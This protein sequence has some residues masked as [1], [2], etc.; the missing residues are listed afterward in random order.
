MNQGR[1]ALG[2]TGIPG[3]PAEAKE[4]LYLLD[5][6]HSIEVND[7]NKLRGY[8]RI[9]SCRSA[10]SFVR[11]RT[12]PKTFHAFAHQQG[13]WEIEVL[14]PS[15]ITNH[16]VYGDRRLAVSLANAPYGYSGV[17]PRYL[18][19]K[20]AI[21]RARC[22]RSGKGFAV[23]RTLIS[24]NR[25]DK[26]MSLVDILG[27]VSENGNYAVRCRLV[28]APPSYGSRSGVTL[29][30]CVPGN[31][32]T[33]HGQCK[34]GQDVKH[35]VLLHEDGRKNYEDPPQCKSPIRPHAMPKHQRS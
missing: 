29:R 5:A 28:R 32:K 15:D 12:S 25:N 16:L 24:K 4:R 33:Q 27:S 17:F 2:Q 18:I 30:N 21:Q 9:R 19:R 8:V 22:S 3:F 11:L 14:S 23:R 26:R 10:L 13:Q 6:V 31:D 34:T 35:V 20:L 1:L 7:L